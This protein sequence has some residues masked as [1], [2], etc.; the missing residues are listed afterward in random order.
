MRDVVWR[1]LYS[2]TSPK[3]SMPTAA[4]VIIWITKSPKKMIRSLIIQTI[5]CI[6]GPNISVSYSIVRSLVHK[7]KAVAA[8]KKSK[9]NDSSLM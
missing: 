6:R 8:S 9:L 3:I 2:G 1:S 4:K 5:I 7:N